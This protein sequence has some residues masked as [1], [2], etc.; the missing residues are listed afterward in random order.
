ME[1]RQTFIKR[2][3]SEGEG[4]MLIDFHSGIVLVSF[5]I[6]IILCIYQLKIKQKSNTYLLFL[7]IFYIYIM[8]VINVTQFPIIIH[9]DGSASSMREAI[10]AN[11]Y[12]MPFPDGLSVNYLLSAP[13]V[14]NIV[15]T[16]P[17]GFGLSF[18]MTTNWRKIIIAGLLIGLTIEFLQFLVLIINRFHLRLVMMDD[19][20][21][22][23]IGV[24]IGYAL[25]KLFARTYL[26]LVSN[27]HR[28]VNAVAQYID[29]VSKNHTDWRK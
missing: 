5:F 23:F 27:T 3:L 20:M 24:I 2:P 18:I 15:M 11:V 14:L 9:D 1:L 28:N 13:V 25:F 12:L 21:F 8:G 17:F 16:V 7:T 29:D 4:R 19:V 22:N 6:W 26:Q 10:A